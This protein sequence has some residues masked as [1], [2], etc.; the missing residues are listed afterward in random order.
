MEEN[1][2]YQ[3]QARENAAAQAAQS[4]EQTAE[5]LAEQARIRREKLAKLQGEGKNPYEQVKYP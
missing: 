1:K 4:P 2:Q 5:T 3:G